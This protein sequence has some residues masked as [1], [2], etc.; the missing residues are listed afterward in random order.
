MSKR[1]PSCGQALPEYGGIVADEERGE[2]RFQGRV[3]YLPRTE[4]QL[5]E[6]LL[7]K[8]GRLA[9]KASIMEF[10]YQLRQEEPEIKIV[11]VLVCKMR[12]K[13]TRIGIEIGTQ[14]GQGYFI[15]PIEQ[16]ACAA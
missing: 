6:F 16:E 15:R 14:W 5:F 10:L 9:S 4:F 7:S 12:K 1:C 11:D 2:V 3:V 13:L 8:K